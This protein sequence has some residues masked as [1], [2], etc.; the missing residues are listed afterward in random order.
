MRPAA[1][2]AA[3]EAGAAELGLAA[4]DEAGKPD[5]LAGAELERD[6]GHRAVGG[7]EALDLEQGP[8]RREGD[9]R[10]DLGDDAAGHELQQALVIGLVHGERGDA[11][12]VAQHG[13]AVADAPV[14]V[15]AVADIDDADAVALLLLDE[16]E[17]PL[18]LAFGERRG[19]LVQD[20]HRGLGAERLGDLHHLLLGA[21]EILHALARPQRKAQAD[22][23]SPA[24][25]GAA[26]AC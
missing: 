26:P 11:L 18:R 20:Q 9:L 6:L 1:I 8:P 10:E 15:H 23:G 19:R 12:A 3:R 13:D 22:P 17:E 16:R 5:D 24:P 25:G 14:L 7:G 21:G 4:A 2:G